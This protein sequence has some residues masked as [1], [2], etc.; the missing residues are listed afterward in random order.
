MNLNT[1]SKTITLSPTEKG[2][3]EEIKGLAATTA[4]QPFVTA[5]QI[6]VCDNLRKATGEYQAVMESLAPVKK[7]QAALPIVEEKPAAKKKEL[8]APF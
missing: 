8:T 7:R 4:A 6:K 2:W 1:R 3:L 5:E